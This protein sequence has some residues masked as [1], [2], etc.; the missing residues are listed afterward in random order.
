M[1]T[2]DVKG[3]EEI[4]SILEEVGTIMPEGDSISIAS[5]DYYKIILK[6]GHFINEQNRPTFPSGLLRIEEVISLTGVISKHSIYNLI[7]I[8]GFPKGEKI[9]ILGRPTAWNQA[10][11]EDWMSKQDV[12][13]GILKT[14][15]T[16]K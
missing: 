8:K 12:D 15:D 11:I 4:I 13:N 7:K 9:P 16:L 14:I 2:I 1:K 10:A 3:A 5:R 6:I